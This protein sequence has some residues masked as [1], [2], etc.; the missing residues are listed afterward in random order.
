[1]VSAARWPWRPPGKLQQ[2]LHRLRFPL[3][4][5][6]ENFVEVNSR[7]PSWRC[8]CCNQP[9]S[10]IDLC[11]DQNMVQILSKTGLDT[12]DVIIFADGSWKAVA[13]HNRSTNQ[14]HDGTIAVQED[15][16]FGCESNRFSNALTNVVDL[17]IE[18]N[19]ESDILNG[20]VKWVGDIEDTKP[21]KN[22]PVFSVSE[23]SSPSPLGSCIAVTTQAA[24]DQM[25]NDTWLRNWSSTSTF[26]GSTTS[27]TLPDSR[28]DGTLASLVPNFVLNPVITDAVSPALNQ[29]LAAS[30]EF[31][32]PT[33]WSIP[34]V[35]QENMHTQ[36][37]HFGNS[38]MGTV[39]ER[40]LIPRT[41]TRMPIA[42]PTL[43]IWSQVSSSTQRTQMN[44]V[45]FNITPNINRSTLL[46]TIPSVRAI[47]H[48]FSA[49]SNDSQVQQVSRTLDV[50]FP[51]QGLHSMTQIQDHEGHH[52][53]LN[54]TF[55]QVVGLPALDQV[56]MRTSVDQQ[57]RLGAY[58]AQPQT[59]SD[60]HNSHHQLRSLRTHQS[61]SHCTDILPQS[62]CIPSM[63]ACQASQNATAMSSGSLSNDWNQL[64]DAHHAMQIRP[65]SGMVLSCTS[66]SGLSFQATA[67]GFRQAS[68]EQLQN[69]FGGLQAVARFNS[70]AESPSE[71]NWQPMGRMR[72][73]LTGEAY[74]AALRH[75]AAQ[76][77]QQVPANWRHG[78]L[79]NQPGGLSI[80]A[81]LKLWALIGCDCMVSFGGTLSN[82]TYLI[83]V[84]SYDMTGPA[85]DVNMMGYANSKQIASGVHFRLK[86]RSFIVAEPGGNR[87]VFVNLDAC[88]ASQLVTIKVIERLKS[89]QVDLIVFYFGRYGGIY[90]EQNV[91]ISGIH[92]H[93]G[94]GGYL[95]YVVYIVTS[96]GFVRQSFDVIVD[97][98]EKS[99][100]QAH[101]NLRP[102]NIFVN[103][104]EL[105]DAGVNRSPSAYL[106]NPA[107]ERS[108]YKYD[109]DKEMT[110]LKF[111]DD[112][113]GP[114]G[115]FN[116]FATHGTS[117]S[118][119][120]SLIS[121]DNKGAAARFMEDWAE[122]KGFPKGIN[123]IYDDAFVVGSK[124]K[125][126]V[127]SIIPQPHE[128]FNE[129]QQ[130][131]SS[132]QA[133]GGR[134]LASSLSVSQRVRSDQG[135]KPKFVSAFCQSN[136]GDVSPN[137]L[138][139]FCI[140]T[141]LPCD[142]N[143]STC[144][145]KN[146]LCYGRGPGYPDEFESTRIIG[147]RQ[148]I[149]AMDLF[150]TASEQVK[151]KVDYRHT[152]IDFSQLEV[153][154]P[155]SS[156]G[157]E[158]VQTCPAAMG[159]SFAAGTT[160]GPG[161]FDFKQ[162]DD[163]GNPFWKLVRNLLKTPTKEQI[164]CQKP[165]PILLDTAFNTSNPD[166]PNRTSGYP[167]CTWRLIST[168]ALNFLTL[169]LFKEFT[170]MAGRRLRDA[171]Q[172]VLTS[173]GAGEFGSNIHIVIA[174]LS[175]T[176][177]QYVTTF[178]EYQIQRYEGASTLYGPHTLSAYIQ[179]FKKLASAL[180]SGQ[181]VQPGPQPPDLLD[182]QIGLLP[183]VV[184]DTTP[185][186][187][188]FGDVSTDVPENSTFKPGDMVTATFWSA[189]PRNDLLTDG[190]FALV[191]IL[192]GSNT[193]IP[194]YDD[195]DFCL[196]FKWSR[197]SKLSS[198]SHATIEWWI[199]E[200]AI[201]GIY[202]LRHFGA[203]KSLFGSIKH[204]TGTSHA[205][206]VL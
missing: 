182:K 111:V 165:K 132:F 13:D 147:E 75:Y 62:S 38:A 188:K 193:W 45:A 186:G 52:N 7:K 166:N 2:P 184:V 91:A 203:S 1:M 43:P 60:I 33:L 163:K 154:L 23:S 105:Q 87:M 68:N 156:G 54:P 109:V 74:S 149:K 10:Y 129:L 94:P 161:A 198:R 79:I 11:I 31:F 136:C 41:V 17:T 116:W 191:E 128:N 20:S 106:N 35:R 169:F 180:I 15:G 61:M 150:N 131:A 72:G 112:E 8:P 4:F 19:G 86:A 83:G 18:D 30:H 153:N 145:G 144:N 28:I 46:S 178:E 3:C 189:C 71:L 47:P 24:S 162:G 110:L 115:S 27:T 183:G 168:M 97:G 56:G 42:V 65:R 95:Q 194:A 179:E 67:G 134:L 93:A 172:T 6:Y 84:G 85:A 53:I 119:T 199:P 59:L 96:L 130:L 167:M 58:R 192:D 125:R 32:Q 176:Y 92:T 76:P 82:S 122:Q 143:H 34:Q 123:S 206:V 202:R 22:V 5:D 174:G 104:G 66:R 185:I 181:N 117:M 158:V 204:F 124:P 127:S 133:S 139:T 157:Q 37:L 40:P 160:D 205:F 171:V 103:K 200:T 118:R 48:G 70:F 177:S 81:S 14:L 138:G 77:T 141:G 201:S 195:D 173:G 108:Q 88:M 148:F 98:I 16:N 126:R 49:M 107:A 146:E 137:V 114:V 151:G 121:G 197:P 57:T 80:R 135:N 69:T 164:E 120:N 25:G 64:L 12:D 90:N 26:N 113:W 78:N 21:F 99:I 63:Q 170:T 196:R 140:D 101:E 187:V 51:S 175:N 100:I 102:G 159:F 50:V 89:R 55:Q 39:S 9:A 152:Y 36:E 73:S 29:E 155:S 44:V 142:F 190:T